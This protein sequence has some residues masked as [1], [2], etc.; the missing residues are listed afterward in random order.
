[1]FLNRQTLKVVAKDLI[2]L[3]PN[4]NSSSPK[5]LPFGRASFFNDVNV[6]ELNDTVSKSYFQDP[7][8]VPIK[9]TNFQMKIGLY[10]I[11]FNPLIESFV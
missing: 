8:L 2:V 10:W 6:T 4:Q 11:N 1:L 5:Q 3:T 9:K 7:D